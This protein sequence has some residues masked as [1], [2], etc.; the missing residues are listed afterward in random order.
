MAQKLPAQP[1]AAQ[2]AAREP[3]EAKIASDTAQLLASRRGGA[4]RHGG[5]RLRV[6]AVYAIQ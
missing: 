5:T 4:C 6:L 1:G 2:E 3:A